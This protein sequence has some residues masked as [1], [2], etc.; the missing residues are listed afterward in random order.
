MAKK[1]QAETV[2]FMRRIPYDVKTMFKAACAK[3]GET[4]QDALLQ[5]M[6]HYIYEVEHPSFLRNA[7]YLKLHPQVPVLRLIL[8]PR[9]SHKRKNVQSPKEDVL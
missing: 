4:M 5:F 1:K 9:K 7:A 8:P 2:F 3:R 6:K